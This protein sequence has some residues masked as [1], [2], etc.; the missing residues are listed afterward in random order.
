M[1]TKDKFIKFLKKHGALRKYKANVK[2]QDHV[3]FDETIDSCD[4]GNNHY[5]GAAFTWSKSPEGIDYWAKLSKLWN[6]E[7]AK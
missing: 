4:K 2:Q 3:S 6:A 7:S 5:V 1:T